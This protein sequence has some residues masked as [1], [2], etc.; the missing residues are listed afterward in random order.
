MF[1]HNMPY[2]KQQKLKEKFCSLRGFSINHERFPDE[3]SVE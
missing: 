1:A 2:R 3:C